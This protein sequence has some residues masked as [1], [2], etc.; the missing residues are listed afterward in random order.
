MYVLEIILNY[1]SLFENG[2]VPGTKFEFK[3]R[4]FLLDFPEEGAESLKGVQ[5]G[6]KIKLKF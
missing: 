3:D 4:F 2:F 1:F 6:W 5:D